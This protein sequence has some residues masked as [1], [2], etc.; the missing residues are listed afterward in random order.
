[1]TLFLVPAVQSTYVAAVATYTEFLS[2]CPST[3]FQSFPTLILFP[4]IIKSNSD[5]F[6][7]TNTYTTKLQ[8]ATFGGAH[9]GWRHGE[10]SELRLVQI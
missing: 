3:S 8:S 5:Y 1:M 6:G 4:E 2:W 10:C 9:N 7:L